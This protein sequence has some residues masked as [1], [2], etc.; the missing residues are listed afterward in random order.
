[1]PLAPVNFSLPNPDLL[2]RQSAWLAPARSRLFRRIQIAH[3]RSVLDLGCGWQT[4][5]PELVRRSGGMVVAAD[6]ARQAFDAISAEQPSC[7]RVCCDATRLPFRPE[8]FD[9][10]FCQFAL[11]WF[12]SD[13]AIGEIRRVLCQS[14]IL[15][16]I[17]PDYGGLIESPNEIATSELWE[18]ALRRAGA[19]PRIGRHLPGMLAEAGFRVRVDLLDRLTTPSPLR[20]D[21]LRGLPLTD[22]ETTQL[23]Q[24]VAADAEC[25][26]LQRV[27]HLPTFLVIASRGAL[28][29]SI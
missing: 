3:C 4:V 6:C 24:V 25:P 23:N 20:F 21:L 16:A 11:L 22:A 2:A 8:S 26:P 12:G 1:M 14:G 17:E 27:A 13:A 10:V 15:I 18:A 19:E 9:L 7:Q 28:S 29:V 5:T